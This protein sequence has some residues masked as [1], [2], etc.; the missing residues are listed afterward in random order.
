M[1]RA[2]GI[3]SPCPVTVSSPGGITEAKLGRPG[4]Y[5]FRTIPLDT[6]MPPKVNAPQMPQETLVRMVG[7]VT[8][9]RTNIDRGMRDGSCASCVDTESPALSQI[10]TSNP[11]P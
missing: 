7:I 3:E 1:G 5:D 4:G 11:S 6:H 8:D 2:E 9:S 10:L